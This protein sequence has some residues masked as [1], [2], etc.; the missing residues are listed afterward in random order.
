MF[1]VQRGRLTKRNKMAIDPK[2]KNLI[3]FFVINVGGSAAAI[4]FA[5]RCTF[6]AHLI[7]GNSLMTVYGCYFGRVWSEESVYGYRLHS[8]LCGRLESLSAYVQ[9]GVHILLTEYIAQLISCV[10]TLGLTAQGAT[11]VRQVGYRH[12]N[13]IRYLAVYSEV[14]IYHMF[15]MLGIYYCL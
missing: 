5:I 12:R 1:A 14:L 7:H 11:S 3:R 10:Q 6:S 4:F 15:F 2:V 8:C 9:V 13:H